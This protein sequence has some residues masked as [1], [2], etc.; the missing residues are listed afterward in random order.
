MEKEVVGGA[1]GGS[2]MERLG[3]GRLRRGQREGVERDSIE[4]H[5]RDGTLRTHARILCAC[6]REFSKE[7]A[8]VKSRL[9]FP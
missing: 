3:M 4:A 1:R 7:K 5:T 6:V 9:P 8:L 2:H